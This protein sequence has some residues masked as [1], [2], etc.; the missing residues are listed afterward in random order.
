MVI[1]DRSAY[2]CARAGHLL[3]GEE[4]S[5]SV[6]CFGTLYTR[7]LGGGRRMPPTLGP[8]QQNDAD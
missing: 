8:P 5:F 4:L 1:H 3:C 7:R 2:P 6:D